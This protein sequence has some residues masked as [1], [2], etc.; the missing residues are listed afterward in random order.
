MRKAMLLDKY[1]VHAEEIPKNATQCQD[2]D[3]LVARLTDM[4]KAH[5]TA[6]YIGE[7]DH[8]SHVASQS[9]AKIAE[10][11]KDARHVLFCVANGIPSPMIGAARPRAI[12]IVET[13]DEYVISH[14]EAPVDKANQVMAEWVQALK[15]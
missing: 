10:D 6:A 8:Y 3:A 4:I 12:S 7:F 5:P 2:M 9:D 13:D 1:P 14:L 11:I 15:D